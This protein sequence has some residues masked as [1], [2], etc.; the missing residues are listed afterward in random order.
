[1]RLLHLWQK[2]LSR[3]GD[4]VALVDSISGHLIRFAEIE[5]RACELSDSI[6]T[7]IVITQCEDADFF[8]QLIAAWKTGRPALIGEFTEK[9]PAYIPAS[10][11]LETV[12]IKQ[13][14][15][16][17]G[18]HRSAF[19]SESAVLAEAYANSS[20]VGSGQELPSLAVISMGHSYGFGCLALPLICFGQSVEVLRSPLPALVAA[21]L[22]ESGNRFV[23]AVP[24]IWR[25]WVDAGLLDSSPRI[26]CVTA[27]ARLPSSLE[28]D[29]LERTGVPLHS[30]YGSTETGAVSFHGDGRLR[31]DER[32]V[33]APLPG[34]EVR[35]DA[36][37][38]VLVSSPSVCLGVDYKV[39]GETQSGSTRTTF[40]LGHHSNGELLLHGTCGEAANVAGRKVSLKHVENRL[41][42]LPAID[43]IKLHR[44]SSISPERGDEIRAVVRAAQKSTPRSLRA[45]AY[46]VLD[47][48]EVPRH[49]DIIS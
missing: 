48:W 5:K 27:G 45:A 25:Y 34:V 32:S 8:A 2:T 26:R 49:W 6:D 41:R 39:E 30:L 38:R 37:G 7:D 14:C 24:A 21:A 12:L 1:M 29:M 10:A 42:S 17:A 18:I 23:P 22:A 47:T 11:P 36:D 44:E 3:R 46:D 19:F 4:D 31:S 35:I 33:G 9:T 20:V 28:R 13:G 15:G 43:S 40:D 16:A